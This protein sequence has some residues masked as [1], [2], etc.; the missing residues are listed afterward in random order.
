MT[1]VILV[2]TEVS[3]RDDDGGDDNGAEN[4]GHVNGGD[5]SRTTFL[6]EKSSY[7]KVRMQIF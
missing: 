1:V 5:D 2:M 3:G 6:V 7:T 4:G